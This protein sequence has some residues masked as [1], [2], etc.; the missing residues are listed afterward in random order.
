MGLDEE[1]EGQKDD[2][3]KDSKIMNSLIRNKR[4]DVGANTN[5]G[6]EGQQPTTVA[7]DGF[8]TFI[9]GVKTGVESGLKKVGEFVNKAGKAVK[10]IADQVFGQKETS[11]N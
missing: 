2:T 3:N 7:P 9:E 11:S 10:G 4:E 8:K 6:Q 5:S 1:S